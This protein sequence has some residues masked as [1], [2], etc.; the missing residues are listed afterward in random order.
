MIL[1][2][3]DWS[4]FA[5]SG[6][7]NWVSPCLVSV[8]NKNGWRRFLSCDLLFPFGTTAAASPSLLCKFGPFFRHNAALTRR[9]GGRDEGIGK[10][11]YLVRWRLSLHGVV[12][13]IYGLAGASG[14][15]H[16]SSL[17]LLP[18]VWEILTCFDSP[19]FF[20]YLLYLRFSLS[21]HAVEQAK[22][23]ATDTQPFG[24]VRARSKFHLS[25][26]L[27][28]RLCLRAL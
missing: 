21:F 20:Y 12:P 18:C 2:R 22:K 13:K 17:R 15:N 16:D 4:A 24:T 26:L 27:C 25:G 7:A 5:G 9:E 6:V 23:E 19:P 10:C 14:K 11:A 28:G 1:E 3:L 8:G